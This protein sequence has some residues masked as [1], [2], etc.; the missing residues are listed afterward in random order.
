MKKML[1]K[2]NGDVNVWGMMLQTII[3]N[4]DEVEK[5]LFDGWHLNPN[6]TKILPDPE[7][8]QKKYNRR[9]KNADNN[10]G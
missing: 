7:K 3:V 2:S 8:K 9:V 1:Y 10:E 6:D 4:A 5:Y